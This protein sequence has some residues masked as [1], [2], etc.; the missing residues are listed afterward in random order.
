MAVPEY[1]TTIVYNSDTYYVRN[2]IMSDKAFFLETFADFPTEK[3]NANNERLFERLIN[4][5]LTHLLNPNK[6]YLPAIQGW[7]A[8]PNNIYFKNDVP[9]GIQYADLLWEGSN[10][11]SRNSTIAIHPDF[12]GQGLT[13]V[14]N[15]HGQYWTYRD[16]ADLPTQETHYE[17]PHT[18]ITGR[19]H[20]KDRSYTHTKSRQANTFGSHNTAPVIHH[21]SHTKE[22]RYDY[23]PGA[24]YEVTLHEYEFTN[25]R[26]GTKYVTSGKRDEE[27]A[28]TVSTPSLDRDL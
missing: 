22:Q 25:E 12:R 24:T 19:Q 6:G 8:H 1:H 21:F 3:P 16:G 2:L 9:F 7:E 17:M 28:G 4:K 5:W 11:I 13:A 20:Q 26:Y 18:N 10:L 27:L 14:I 15:G 23:T